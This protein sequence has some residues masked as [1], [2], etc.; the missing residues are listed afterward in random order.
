MALSGAWQLCCQATHPHARLKPSARACVAM[1]VRLP[2]SQPLG[3]RCTNLAGTS[4]LHVQTRVC[5]GCVIARY[6]GPECQRA[7][8]KEHKPACTALQASRQG[9]PAC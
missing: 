4:E 6:C 7:A 5:S 8:W 3:R 9:K 1:M 2:L